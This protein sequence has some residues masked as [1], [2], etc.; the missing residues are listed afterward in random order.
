MDCKL[1]VQQV[2]HREKVLTEQRKKKLIKF[3]IIIFVI[4]AV[5]A[6]IWI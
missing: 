4:C 1:T 6:A 2:E 3:S 5:V